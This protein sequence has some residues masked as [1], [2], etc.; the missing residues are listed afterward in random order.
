MVDGGMARRSATE[1]L[2]AFESVLEEDGPAVLAF[3]I[4]RAGPD[5]GEDVFQ[6]S[7]IAALRAYA[8]LRDPEAVRPWLF[9]IA[10]RKAIDAFRAAARAPAPV[11]DVDRLAGEN[12]PPVFEAGIWTQVKSLPDKQRQAVGLRFL[13]DLSHG[14]IGEAMG[15]SEEASRRNVHEGLRRLRR[16][17]GD[18]LTFSEAASS[19]EA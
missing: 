17:L 3:C 16:E 12:D 10:A 1:T 4:S 9:A 5:L 18:D 11:E 15:T 13:A 19:Q 14:E 7:M 2:P 8:D 6:E